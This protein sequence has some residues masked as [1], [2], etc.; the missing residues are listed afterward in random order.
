MKNLVKYGEGVLL[1]IAG[2]LTTQLKIINYIHG[3]ALINTYQQQGEIVNGVHTSGQ[4]V[5]EYTWLP[6]VLGLLLITCGV[7]RIVKER[8]YETR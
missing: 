5:W 7:I 2:L 1:I 3:G 4:V 8:L 6:I